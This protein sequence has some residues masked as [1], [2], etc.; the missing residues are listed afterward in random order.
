[1]KVSAET[2]SSS[3]VPVVQN[4]YNIVDVDASMDDLRG[5]A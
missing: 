5:K 3:A 2:H 1:M 4:K